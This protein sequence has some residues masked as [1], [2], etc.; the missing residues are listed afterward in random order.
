MSRWMDTFFRLS[1]LEAWTEGH[2]SSY[3][4]TLSG[5]LADAAKKTSLT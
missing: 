4:F 5:M 1:G 3:A 2:R